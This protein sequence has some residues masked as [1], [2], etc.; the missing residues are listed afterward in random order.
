M[1]WCCGLRKAMAI[2]KVRTCNTN[3]SR[4][5]GVILHGNGGEIRKRM[6]SLVW[7]Q[8]RPSSPPEFAQTTGTPGH[9]LVAL[10]TS[11]ATTHTVVP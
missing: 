10:D 1:C 6:G 2:V 5:E 9:T 8:S 4:N 7:G 11:G 3:R